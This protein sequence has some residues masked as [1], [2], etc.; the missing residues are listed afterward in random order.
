MSETEATE[1]PSTA[2]MYDYYLGGTANTAAERAA[3]EHLLSII[4]EVSETAWANRGFLQRAVKAM[5]QDWGINQFLDIGA[6][7]P[8]QR[9]THDV[10]A[11]FRSDGRVV[12]V[13]HDPRVVERGLALLGGVD[14]VAVLQGDVRRPKEILNH[15]ETRRLIDFSQPVGV[16]LVALIHFVPDDDDPWGL[17]REYMD[18]VPSGSYLALSSGTG[19]RQAA[20]LNNAAAEAYK[21]SASP[22]ANRTYAQISKFFD[23]LEIV[24]PYEGAEPVLT[25]VGQWG[26]EDPEAADDEGSRWAYAAV[27]RKP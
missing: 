1:R 17:V 23:G 9:N 25:Y 13:D 19:D 10:V 20:R 15:P 14:N 2:G 16:L 11:D 24:P 8:T 26:A 4:P 5:A 3:C 7:L 6:G 21:K 22:A 12:Y 27:A 18:A